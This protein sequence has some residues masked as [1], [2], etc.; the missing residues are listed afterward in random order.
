M[1]GKERIVINKKNQ[2][3]LAGNKNWILIGIAIKTTPTRIKSK[4]LKPEH[5]FDRK[6]TDANSITMLLPTLKATRDE[7]K[8]LYKIN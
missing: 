3:I 6:L 8:I 7:I 2:I 4:V 1:Y 5:Q